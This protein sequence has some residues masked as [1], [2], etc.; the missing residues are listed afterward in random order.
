M[1]LPEKEKTLMEIA[2]TGMIGAVLAAA[3]QVIRALRE[4]AGEPFNPRRFLVGMV[5]AGGVGFIAA[6]FLDSVGVDRQMSGVLIAMCGY[7]GGPL[8]DL[9]IAEVPETIKA[10]FD[11]LQK[12]L[13]EGGRLKK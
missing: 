9:L 4:H 13:T 10:G 5:G 12:W 1:P 3:F 7:V 6:L 11:G 8:L 2:I